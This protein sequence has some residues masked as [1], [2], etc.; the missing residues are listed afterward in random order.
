MRYVKYLDIEVVEE[1][2]NVNGDEKVNNK[3][4]TVLMRYVKYKDI[5][6]N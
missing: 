4:I 6:I 5:E 1:A 2:L 3:D